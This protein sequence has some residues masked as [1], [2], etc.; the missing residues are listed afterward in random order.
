MAGLLDVL[1]SDLVKTIFS[2]ESGPNRTPQN[3]MVD[4]LSMCPFL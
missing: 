1:G 3:K 2:V 4:L